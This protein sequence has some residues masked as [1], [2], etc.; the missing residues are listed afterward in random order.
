MERTLDTTSTG[1]KWSARVL[2]AIAGLWI[3]VSVLMVLSGH[4][5][6]LDAL[7]F[8]N[9]SFLGIVGFLSLIAYFCVRPKS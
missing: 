2:L 8:T 6:L 3:V 4:R 9:P 1:R 5:S 7:D